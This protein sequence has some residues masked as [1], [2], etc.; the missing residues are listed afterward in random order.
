LSGDQGRQLAKKLKGHR[1][2]SNLTH[3]PGNGGA[4][5]FSVSIHSRKSVQFSEIGRVLQ[6]ISPSARL[7]EVVFTGPPPAKKAPKPG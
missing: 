6:A 4:D 5:H 3:R 1:S 2:V 7:K